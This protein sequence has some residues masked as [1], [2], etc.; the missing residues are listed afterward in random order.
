M[1][2]TCNHVWKVGGEILPNWSLS[3]RVALLLPHEFCWSR[4]GE[5]Q[6]GYDI[7][8]KCHLAARSLKYKGEKA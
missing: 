2:K 6:E 8:S 3:K 5:K 1:T 7:C 4:P